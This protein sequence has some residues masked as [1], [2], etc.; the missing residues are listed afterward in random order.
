MIVDCEFCSN[1]KFYLKVK[2]SQIKLTNVHFYAMV[3][4]DIFLRFSFRIINNL[5][6]IQDSRW[7][8]K[9]Q[10]KNPFL[11]IERKSKVPYYVSNL[12]VILHIFHEHF[13]VSNNYC[14]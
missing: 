6:H 13:F 2:Q 4:D 7:L 3:D 14:R 10:E 9:H 11:F 8:L 12:T 1:N 5:C